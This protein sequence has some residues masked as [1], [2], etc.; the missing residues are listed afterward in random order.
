MSFTFGYQIIMLHAHLPYV[1]HKGYDPHFLEEIWLNEAINET[2]I[3]L[4]HSFRNLK[5]EGVKFK[6]TMSFTPTLVSMLKD[7]YLQDNYLSYINRQIELANKEVKRTTYDLHLNYLSK[8]YLDKFEYHKKLF[9]ELDKDII[10]GFKEFQQDGSLEVITCAA[11]HGFL[12]ILESEP[13]SI[14]AQISIGRR[15]HRQTWGVEPR[16][17]WLPECGYYK[18]VEKFLS[19]EG[20]RYFFVD[21]H[22][23]KNAVPRPKFGLYAPVEIGSGVFAF[24]R[25]P[26]SSSQVWSAKE[27]YPGDYRYREYYRDIGYDLD[28]DYI[29]DYVHPTGIRLNTGI[30]YHRITGLSNHKDYYHPDWAMEAAGNHAE[31]FLRSRITQA[32][33]IYKEEKQPPIIISPYDAELF[34][35]WWYE[36]PT[37]LEYLFKKIHFDQN[38]ITTIHPL[39]VLGVLPRIQSVEMDMSS[40]GE[41]G[42]ADVWLN[43]S[44]EWIYKH[45]MECTVSM[46]EETHK[47]IKSADEVNKRILNQMARELLLL[48]SS[49]WPFIMKTG[50]MTE[51]AAKR[52]RVHTNLY[53]ELR[54]MLNSENKNL[55]RLAAIE[56]EH[57]IFE[58]ISYDIF[59]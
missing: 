17:I 53:L 34:G 6:I 1:R 51:Y 5:R 13:S 19:D 28:Y 16:G 25:D 20:I 52:I 21:S 50:T 7:K 11:T 47:Y 8:Y 31:N 18:G 29:K 26:E 12:P 59:A 3:P 30:K 22:G 24:P 33:R 4:I 2:Y 43:P 48:Q 32:H 15:L 10:N 55:E 44:N 40:W 23:V 41:D 49:D 58:D 35:H 9:L 42:Y 45:V 38:E 54:D 14:R 56:A 39:Q 37:F 27:G 46:H 36:G 57:P